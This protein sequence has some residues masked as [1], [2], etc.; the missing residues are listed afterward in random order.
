MNDLVIFLKELAR[1]EHGDGS[2]WLAMRIEPMI[3][4]LIRHHT[5]PARAG[6]EFSRIL[7]EHRG[8]LMTEWGVD[9]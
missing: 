7:D 3:E 2:S 1:H 4:D 8:Q 6:A 5:G 9:R